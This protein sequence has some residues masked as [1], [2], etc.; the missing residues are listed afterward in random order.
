MNIRHTLV[1]LLVL[2]AAMPSSA[3]D[4][5]RKTLREASSRK[6]RPCRAAPNRQAWLA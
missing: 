4:K 2:T 5:K 1:F 3:H 6:W